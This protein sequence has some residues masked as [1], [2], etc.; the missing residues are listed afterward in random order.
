VADW[1]DPR[2][3]AEVHAWIRARADVTGPI[4]QPHIR[5][6]STVLRV[7]TSDGTAW[8][9]A[10][11]PASA[12]EAAVVSVLARERPDVA[13]PLLALDLERGWMLTADAGERLRDVIARE[14]DLRGWLDVLAVYAG[15]Q[16]DM[17][18]HAEELVALGVPD[19]RLA[20]LADQA[21]EVGDLRPDVP[22]I[23]ELSARLATYGIPETIQHD[24]LG[25]GDFF[26]GGACPRILDWGDSCVSHPFLT[27]S[28]TLE[29]VIGWGLE[30]IERSEELGPYRDA[31]LA[32]FERYATHDELEEALDL[33]LRLGWVCRILDSHRGGL[34][35][36]ESAVREQELER[37]QVHLRMFRTGLSE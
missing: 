6:W 32:P 36:R 31:Y 24:D 33:A 9:K 10:N 15:L 2:W 26:L 30:D 28:V 11:A 13:P 21:A 16:I 29:G 4:E 8:F 20:T 17:A 27:M 25:D 12:H 19:C 35:D 37:R 1:T 7:P 3:L 34:A 14:R 22:R 18:S 5:L 23:A